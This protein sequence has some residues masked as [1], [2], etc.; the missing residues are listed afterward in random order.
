MNQSSP[1]AS[2]VEKPSAEY[3]ARLSSPA[4][5]RRRRSRAFWKKI[6]W[7]MTVRS[8]EVAKRILDIVGS[9]FALLCFAPVFAVIAIAIKIEDGGPLFFSQPRYGLGGRLFDCWKLRSMVPNADL[10]MKEMMKKNSHGD[11]V[12]FKLKVDPRITKVGKWIRR[13]SL[14]EFPQFWNVFRGDMSLV[15]PRPHMLVE[16]AKYNAFHLRRLTAKPG[17]TCVW[18]ITGRSDIPFEKQL[19]LDME[20]IRSQSLWSDIMILL[21][22]PGAVILGRGAY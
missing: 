19:R 11:G 2:F 10:M 8:A 4:S 5:V 7:K 13:F 20:Y 14:D 17:L 18:Q 22:T 9:G 15:G 6:A 1:Q 16:V 21:K 3:W 12:T